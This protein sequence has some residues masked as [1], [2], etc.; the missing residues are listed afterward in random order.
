MTDPRVGHK[1]GSCW[2]AWPWD[3]SLDATASSVLECGVFM[4]AFGR[5]AEIIGI[6]RLVKTMYFGRLVMANCV[7]RKGHD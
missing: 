2:A 4:S 1:A 3:I 5:C 7:A 6:I